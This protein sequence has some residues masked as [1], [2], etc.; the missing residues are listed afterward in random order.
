MSRAQPWSGVMSGIMSRVMSGI[1]SGVLYT[2]SCPGFVRYHVWRRVR[3]QRVSCPVC[4]VP[5]CWYVC[6]PTPCLSSCA[7]YLSAEL[8]VFHLVGHH[9]TGDAAG[10]R[11]YPELQQSPVQLRLQLLAH[12]GSAGRTAGGGER[13]SHI[14]RRDS[15]NRTYMYTGWRVAA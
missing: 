6:S 5:R 9:S 4:I 11:L 7:Q 13:Y 12:L 3:Y 2:V 10:A 15:Y 1:V 8:E 14:T